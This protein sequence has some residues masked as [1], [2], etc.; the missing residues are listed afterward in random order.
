LEERRQKLAVQQKE[1]EMIE[2]RLHR[3]LKEKEK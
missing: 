2:Q 1:L 3:K